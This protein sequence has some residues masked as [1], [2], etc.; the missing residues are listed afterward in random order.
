MIRKLRVRGYKSLRD[1]QLSL[2]T[3]AVLTG[4]NASGKSNLFDALKLLSRAV[5]S[6][7]LNEAFDHQRGSRL[8]AFSLGEDGIQ[9]LRRQGRAAL[10]FEVEICL[11]PQVA[12]EVNREIQ[13]LDGISMGLP[14]PVTDNQP[15]RYR[16]SVEIKTESG[17]LRVMEEKLTRCT[18]PEQPI[19]RRSGEEMRIEGGVRKGG[20]VRVSPQQIGV[21]AH[22]AQDA[23]DEGMLAFTRELSGWRFYQLEPGAMRAEAPLKT[24]ER[25][26]DNGADLAAFFN[27]L[28]VENPRQFKFLQKTVATLL[29]AVDG[30]QIQQDSQGIL[31]LAV[32][33]EGVS[34]SIRVV[35]EGTLKILGLVAAFSPKSLD[36]T[37]T[38]G[39]EEPETGVHPRRLRLVADLLQNA[40]EREDGTQVLATTHSPALPECFDP[41]ALIMCR[42]RGRES[43]FESLRGAMESNAGGEFPDSYAAR[44]MRGDFDG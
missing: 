31:Q 28:Q 26:R 20:T 23:Y 41:A 18:Q 10:E 14:R 11:S 21:S 6:G 32:I 2:G 12:R 1:V 9:G 25:L 43:I 40:A 19:L 15:Y 3:L 4:P 39:C 5:S 24:A 38:L 35:S 34:Y 36:A 44:V 8:E 16:L 37:T 33:E 27:T 42:K 22:S 17:A 29:P 30:V 13:N 7:N